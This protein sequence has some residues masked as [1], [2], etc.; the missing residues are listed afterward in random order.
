M[1]TLSSRIRAAAIG[2][3]PHHSAEFISSWIGQ[4]SFDELA[5]AD[6]IWGYFSEWLR[7]R[8]DDRRMALLFLAEAVK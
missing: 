1:T 3:V 2:P 6:L 5:D 7:M 8:N 4:R